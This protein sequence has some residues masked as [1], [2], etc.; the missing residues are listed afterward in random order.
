[1]HRTQFTRQRTNLYRPNTRPNTTGSR[2]KRRFLS[3]QSV[4][5]EH[6]GKSRE[7][8]PEAK[9]ERGSTVT[10]TVKKLWRWALLSTPFIPAC[11]VT[12]QDIK[13]NWEYAVLAGVIIVVTIGAGVESAIIRRKE[14]K[15]KK[16]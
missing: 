14:E 16:E 3:R 13:D 12:K 5:C 2:E 4:F 8:Q 1:M 6:Q 9:S 15:E 10:R 7:I 11:S